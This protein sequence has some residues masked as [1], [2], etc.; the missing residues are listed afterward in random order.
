[1]AILELSRLTVVIHLMQT[2][3]METTSVPA[4]TL[5]TIQSLVPLLHTLPVP[6]HQLHAT[7]TSMVATMVILWAKMS[8]LEQ[9]TVILH[10]VT[11]TDLNSTGKSLHLPLQDSKLG[12]ISQC[13]HSPFLVTEDMEEET[14]TV[15]SSKS[16]LTVHWVVSLCLPT[17]CLL[18]MESPSPPLPLLQPPCSLSEPQ[19]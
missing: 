13:T 10:Q 1:M 4:S 15:W 2:L 5:K 19:V 9:L 16:W 12:Y 11:T 8:L 6:T 7:R 3:L 14:T 18:S 17:G